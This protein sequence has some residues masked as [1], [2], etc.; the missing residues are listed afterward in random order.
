M[1]VFVVVIFFLVKVFL[2]DLISFFVLIVGMFVVF[3]IG[4]FFMMKVLLGWKII[5]FK[6]FVFGVGFCQMLG[7]LIIYLILNEVC[8]VVGE[9]EEE[10]VYLMFKIMFKL[11]V[12]GMVCMIFI[13]VVGFMVL[14]LQIGFIVKKVVLIYRRS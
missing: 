14:M 1:V 4:I 11:V 6:F 12:G 10:R 9:M 5:G 13:V 2:I 8:N 3:I 7:F